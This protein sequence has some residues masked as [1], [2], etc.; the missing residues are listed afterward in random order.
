MDWGLEK[1][2]MWRSKQKRDRKKQKI[3]VREK[4]KTQILIGGWLGINTI[5]S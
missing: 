2:I 1:H 5:C 4:N 3:G